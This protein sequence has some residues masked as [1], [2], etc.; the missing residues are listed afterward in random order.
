MF[1]QLFLLFLV[2]VGY[3][4]N[5]YNQKS[6]QFREDNPFIGYLTTELPKLYEKASS[7]I[8]KFKL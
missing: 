8:N 3:I 4:Y 7:F 5:Q 1:R 2:I 6:E